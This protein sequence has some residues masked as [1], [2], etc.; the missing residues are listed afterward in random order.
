M[1]TYR[2]TDLIKGAA[3]TSKIPSDDMVKLEKNF[4]IDSIDAD[5]AIGTIHFV[6]T[7]DG[8]P[9]TV[10]AVVNKSKKVRRAV[11][12]AKVGEHTFKC[13]ESM[14]F[15]N[16]FEELQIWMHSINKLDTDEARDGT[17]PLR[18]EE[19]KKVHAGVLD[20]LAEDFDLASV[21]EAQY[22]YG[23][24]QMP[25]YRFH[26]NGFSWFYIRGIELLEYDDK[27]GDFRRHN[28]AYRFCIYIS[29]SYDAKRIK[30]W[31]DV[32]KDS[33]G[34]YFL[35]VVQ[36]ILP[37]GTYK[38]EEWS[39]EGEYDAMLEVYKAIPK[40]LRAFYDNIAKEHKCTRDW[41]KATSWNDDGP[42]YPEGSPERTIVDD[43]L[44]KA[45]A[46]V[47]AVKIQSVRDAVF[48][49]IGVDIFECF[50]GSH[51]ECADCTFMDK[52][53]VH[54][55]YMFPKIRG[56]KLTMVKKDLAVLIQVEDY[57]MYREYHL[58]Y[59]APFR[60]ATLRGMCD[61][62][63]AAKKRDSEHAMQI[64]AGLR[65]VTDYFSTRFANAA[66]PTTFADVK[67]CFDMVDEFLA[68]RGFKKPEVQ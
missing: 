53:V 7:V 43:A 49:D 40:R 6:G 35:N 13:M 50:P 34:P 25:H 64:K 24:V 20:K 1:K 47:A 22:A 11:Y 44:G 30:M 42:E 45:R 23:C 3:Y 18:M 29:L 61:T 67:E 68:Y 59:R 36:A 16:D 32:D 9:A 8:A 39:V 57:D 14:Y 12:T 65:K 37:S 38:D 15:L 46:E 51:V 55:P 5:G 52:V 54:I 48:S 2:N 31:Y 17:L 26:W 60:F 27:L 66:K 33:D 10:D 63:D 19:W 41:T 21:G 56:T 58:S 28:R 4:T 62:F